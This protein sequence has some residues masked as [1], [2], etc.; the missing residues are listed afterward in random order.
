MRKSA[1]SFG[2]LLVFVLL[3]L[4]VY[5]IWV[6]G[7]RATETAPKET[8]QD[9]ETAKPP[10]VPS[11]EEGDPEA[12]EGDQAETGLDVDPPSLP[13][14]VRQMIGETVVNAIH[15]VFYI[16]AGLAIIGFFFALLLQEIEL[17][18]RMAPRGE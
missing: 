8:A 17:T 4:A 2:I 10:A 14:P 13:A 1:T 18:N 12:A 15:P 7:D 16:A 11:P 6:K 5:F 3:C 9:W